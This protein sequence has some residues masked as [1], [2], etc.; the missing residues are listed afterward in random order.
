M[1]SVIYYLSNARYEFTKTG[2]FTMDKIFPNYTVRESSDDSDT[3]VAY[4]W[5]QERLYPSLEQLSDSD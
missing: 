3:T 4:D 5:E 2:K 1:A